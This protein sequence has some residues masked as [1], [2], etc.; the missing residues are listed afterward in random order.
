M[1]IQLAPGTYRDATGE[2]FPL[3]L[4]DGI[5]LQGDRSSQGVTT[6]II[7]E[8]RANRGIQTA[9]IRLQG[10]SQVRGVTVTTPHRG[11]IGILVDAGRPEIRHNTFINNFGAGVVVIGSS[12]PTIADNTFAYQYSAWLAQ[13][14]AGILVQDQA[15]GLIADNDIEGM[16]TGIVVQ[17]QARPRLQNNSIR[18]NANYGVWVQDQARPNLGTQSQPGRNL[19]QE[20]EIYDIYNQTAIAIP[21]HGNRLGIA[22][23]EGAVDYDVVG[24]SSDMTFPDI[25]DH[26]ADDYINAL[27][28]RGVL[29]DFGTSFAPNATVTR[30]EFARMLSR[31]FNQPLE[32]SAPRFADVTPNS[33]G[34]TAIQSAYQMGFMSGNMDG[35]FRPND[36][37]SRVE[38]M[39]ALASG[40]GYDPT[41]LASLRVYRDRAE[42]P[43]MAQ[44]QVAAATENEIVVSYPDP[45]WLYPNTAATRGDVAAMVYQAIA[46]TGDA[47]AIASPY[48]VQA[49]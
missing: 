26:W 18:K 16:E 44:A 46:S 36:P 8:S 38:V 2:Q 3:R 33:P 25:D 11:G 10:D 6:Q 12:T 28:R 37:I 23:I 14:E 7:H 49:P 9:A 45:D 15:G 19:I 47:P 20:N 32:R 21:V 41:D 5:I 43:T 48:G 42:I 13:S 17:D 22:R 24:V 39:I 30:L 31:A 27:A 4:D 40:L 34:Y 1:V 35:N 29:R